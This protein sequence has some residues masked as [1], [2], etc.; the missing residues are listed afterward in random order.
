MKDKIREHGLDWHV[1]SAGT[2]SWH[3]GEGPD[4]RSIETAEKYG[5]DICDQRAR[6]FSPYDYEQFDRI[7]VM[8]SANYR[9]VLR[10]AKN[11]REREKVEMIL[12][13][14]Y[15]GMNRSVPDPYWDDDGFDE[16]FRMLEEA[17]E[18]IIQRA[19]KEQSS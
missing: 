8:D 18:A 14:T 9:D 16:V 3:V 2:G 10:K 4:P 7:Y 17:C 13:V 11:S 12:N 5:L 15:P 19:L 1:E 6:Q